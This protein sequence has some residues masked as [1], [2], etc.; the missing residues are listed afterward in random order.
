[1]P[2]AVTKRYAASEHVLGSKSELGV[3]AAPRR[4]APVQHA[5]VGLLLAR[6]ARLVFGNAGP[7]AWTALTP[8]KCVR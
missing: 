5:L 7:P 1:M 2:Q 4:E 3:V 6:A 8:C